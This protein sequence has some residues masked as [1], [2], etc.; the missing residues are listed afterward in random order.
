MNNLR[1][2]A[3]IDQMEAWIGDPAWEPDP[4][5]LE[6]WNSQYQQALA[7]AEKGEEWPALVARAQHLGPRLEAR[8]RD[9]IQRRNEIKA[10][11]DA[12]ERGN[13][14]LAGYGANTR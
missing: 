11:L 12:Q 13:R 5:D 14:A 3:A 8:L 4:Q 1:V 9:L 10:E 7:G 2:R 6:A